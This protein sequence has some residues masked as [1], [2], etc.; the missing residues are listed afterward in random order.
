MSMRFDPQVPV[1]LRQTQQW[2]ASIITRPMEEDSKMVATSPSGHS[3]EDESKNY[4]TPS[5]TLEPHQRIELYNQQYWWRLLSNMH[6]IYPLVTRLFGYYH[7]NHEIAVPY[8]VKYPPNHWSLN[9]LGSQLPRWLNDN[10]RANDKALVLSSAN[11]DCAFNDCFTTIQK[12]PIDLANLPVTGDITSLLNKKIYLQEHLSLFELDFNLFPFREKFIKEDG[13]YWIDH[14][15]PELPKGKKY[16]FALYRALNNNAAWLEISA[17]EFY[18]LNLFKK[19]TSIEKACGSL[20][21]AN[22]DIAESAMANLHKW[23][24]EWVIRRWLTLDNTKAK[25]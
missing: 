4:I 1:K 6:E 5:P 13:D 12:E 18:L 21:K 22:K 9:Y 3:M 10:Y 23:F 25:K 15:F 17:G 20:E 24:Q 2:F 16:F 8:L 19:G 7:F 14:D 11:I